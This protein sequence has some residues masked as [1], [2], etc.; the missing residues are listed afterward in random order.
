M[1]NLYQRGPTCLG[2]PRRLLINVR[3]RSVDFDPQRLKQYIN[4][5]KKEEAAAQEAR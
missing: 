1:G 4:G 3:L 5:G 2:S